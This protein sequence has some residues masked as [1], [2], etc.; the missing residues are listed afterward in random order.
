MGI[1][2]E[3]YEALRLGRRAVGAEL[4]AS[5]FQAAVQNLHAASTHAQVDLFAARGDAPSAAQPAASAAQP[6]GAAPASPAPA[7]PPPSPLPAP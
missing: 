7:E 6:G 4:K 3:L 5:Y 1:G 2:S